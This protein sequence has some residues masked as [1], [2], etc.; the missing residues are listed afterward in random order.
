MA[1]RWKR[2]FGWLIGL[3]VVGIGVLLC[4]PAGQ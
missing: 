1:R 2:F 4:F 3:L